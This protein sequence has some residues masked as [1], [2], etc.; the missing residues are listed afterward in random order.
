[1]THMSIPNTAIA[2]PIVATAK[3]TFR[4][5]VAALIAQ[6]QKR[7]D[8]IALRNLSDRMLRDIGVTSAERDAMV[9]RSASAFVNFDV[10]I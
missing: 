9:G 6:D 7:R 5:A 4:R 2:F 10:I 8:R 3:A 1:M